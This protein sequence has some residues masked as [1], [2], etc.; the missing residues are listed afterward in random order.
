MG[1]GLVDVYAQVN[2][3]KS[4]FSVVAAVVAGS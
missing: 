4:K 3:I 2:V 1:A